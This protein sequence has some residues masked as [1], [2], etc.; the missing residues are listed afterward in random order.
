M[1]SLA[2]VRFPIL[3][4]ICGA[5]AIYFFA[6]VFTLPNKGVSLL[7]MSLL[8]VVVAELVNLFHQSRPPGFQGSNAIN[9]NGGIVY[10][11][12]IV[13]LFVLIIAVLISIFVFLFAAE[14]LSH[15]SRH[16]LF[17]PLQLLT[18]AGLMG[19]FF[20]DDLFNLVLLS[21]LMTVGASALTAFDIR[22]K[23]SIW[24]GY[25]YLIMNSIATMMMLLGVYF[26][27]RGNGLLSLQV[28]ETQPNQFSRIAAACFLV[29][30]SLKAGVVPLHT[31]IPDVY[32]KAPSIVSGFLAGVLSKSALFIF[33][34]ICI[35]LGLTRSEVGL[36]LLVFSLFNMIL[37]SIR[38][39]NQHHLRKFL[40]FSS[41]TH[42][43]YLMFC[44]GIGLAYE[45]QAAFLAALFQF[46]VIAVLKCLAFLSCGVFEYNFDAI[47]TGDLKGAYS[48][49][50]VATTCFSISLMGLAGIPLLAGFTGK[51]LAFTAALAA[52]DLFA[53]LCLVVFLVSSLISLGGYLP[54]L[55]NQYQK[56]DQPFSKDP[57]SN[58]KPIS[59]W[60]AAPLFGLAG[61]VF[62]LGVFPGA[63]LSILDYLSLWMWK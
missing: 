19:M 62:Y 34:R 5:F 4:L 52:Q 32:S 33:P 14:S 59:A 28:I 53:V 8:L 61:L 24:A 60:M 43:G 29:G 39:L 41:I 54:N 58:K 46:L 7:S 37:G 31:W 36:F 42:T 6:R 21:E 12:N 1:F 56:V 20:S 55:I 50:P 10:S 26:V 40:A 38:S 11:F 22:N 63:V 27:F 9:S 18:L 49:S 30:L 23:E 45:L 25:K 13:G 51:W 44:L 3:I 57:F 2:D 17:Y 16:I 47:S 15:D 35:G 48:Y